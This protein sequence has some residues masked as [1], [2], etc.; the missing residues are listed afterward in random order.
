MLLVLVAVVASVG[1][2]RTKQANNEEA[3]QRKKAENTSA[4]ALE[5]LD[6][7]FQQFAPDRTASASA[8]TVVDDTG[9]EITVPVQPVLSKEAAVLLE[10]MVAF[11]D[12][13]AAQ[14]GDDA[15]LHRKV[16][17]ANR[18]VGDI[19][20]RLGH[21]EESK[22]AYLR[23]IELYKQLAEAPGEN[24]DLRTEIARIQ[25][26][27]G[28]V[29]WAMNDMEAGHASYLDAFATLKAAAAESSA[30]PQYQYE[31]ARTHYYLGKGPGREPGPPPFA[32]GGRRGPRPG[33]SGFDG[34]QGSPPPPGG[35]DSGRADRRFGP[36]DFG[37]GRRGPPPG[38]PGP[39]PSL[40]PKEREESLQKAIDILERLVSRASGCARLSPSACAMLSGGAFRAVWPPPGLG[41]AGRE[42]GNPDHAEVGGRISGC[43]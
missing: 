28:N 4:L 24:T 19:R 38:P 18:R 33:P 8:L 40:S 15:K 9:K 37:P 14:G 34:P 39:F 29:Y 31:L 6:N 10:R 25:N 35:P 23:A 32:L 26:E 20:Q 16:A 12:R 5:A 27:L 21:Y 17:E 30:S 1:Y 43:P 42:Q 36:P 41:S 2:V 11:Y 22:A 3:M 13:L 7:I